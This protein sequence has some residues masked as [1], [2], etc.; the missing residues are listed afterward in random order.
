MFGQFSLSEVAKD[1]GVSKK[2]VQQIYN[3]GIGAYKT[4]PESVRP[5]V[6][7]KE[8][9]AMGRV[10]SA[11]MGGKAA[12]VDAKELKMA[13]GGEMAKGVKK[14]AEHKST[15]KELYERKIKPSQAVK[16]IAREHIQ[17]D[18][19]YYSKMESLKLQNGGGIDFKAM[20]S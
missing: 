16:K 1:T 9:W 10:Y 13:K 15:L 8:Q 5:Q 11:V 7:S 12:R 18:P 17:E 20:V 4:N 3:K 14:E 19:Q 2:G 6:K